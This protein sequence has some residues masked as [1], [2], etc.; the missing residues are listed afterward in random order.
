MNVELRHLR[1]FVTV[2]TELH[3]NRAAAR[4]HMSQPTL[5]QTVR[6][7]EDALGFTLLARTTR[8]VT[9]T[10]NGQMFLAEARAVLER[11][12]GAMRQAERVS[13]GLVGQL[14]L[15]HLIGSAIDHM[16][17]I[18]R[19]F[20]ETYPD[21]SLEVEEYDF[22]SPAAGLDT[23]ASDVA[24]LRPPVDLPAGSEARL[25]RS[26]PRV[27]CV[28]DLHPLAA[29]AEVSVADLLDQPIVAAPG[30]GTWRDYWLL[31]DH[32]GDNAPPVVYEAATFEA[33]LQAVASGRGISI[34]PATAARF[35]ARPGLAF[36]V[37]TDAA[38]CDVAVVL[39]PDPL[40]AARHFA[41]LAARVVGEPAAV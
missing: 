13:S 2:A 3:F 32:R 29:R 18:L 24:I 8:S 35:Y 40:P 33:E 19:A 41:H 14:R 30:S 20:H 15:G 25:L 11:F 27:A 39:P 36:P 10:P 9:L 28:S 6:Q 7:L 16:P 26:E 17:A 34:T 12:D 21:V 22:R 37:I 38:W 4:L 23:G 31:L 5:S 1:A